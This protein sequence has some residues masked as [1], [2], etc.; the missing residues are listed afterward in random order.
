MSIIL[1]KLKTLKTEMPVRLLREFA[2]YNPIVLGLLGKLENKANPVNEVRN[3]LLSEEMTSLI[4]D[5]HVTIGMIKPRLDLYMDTASVSF[6]DDANLTAFLE[7]Q[8]TTLEPVF[9]VSLQMTPD[10]VE[11][12]YGR[13]QPDGSKSPKENMQSHTST[14]GKTVWEEFNDLMA[15]G[16]VTFIVL[17]DRD[18]QAIP[19]WRQEI[20]TK[21]DVDYL[22]ENEPNSLRA[23]FALKNKNNIWH[24]SDGTKSALI[25]LD[26]VAKHMK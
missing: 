4:N 13:K 23:R 12:F 5:G 10:M 20:G 14:S 2:G 17:Y 21:F 19:K 6:K 1:E 24:G 16:P 18:G 26:F 9:S 7:D 15:S 22:R 25:E 11:E 3:I 8:I